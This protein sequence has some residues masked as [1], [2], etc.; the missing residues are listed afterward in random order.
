MTSKCATTARRRHLDAAQRFFLATAVSTVL[1]LAATSANARDTSPAAQAFEQQDYDTAMRLSVP[2][3]QNGDAAAQYRLAMMYR[4]G[5]GVGRDFLLA[6]EWFEKSAAQGY[7]LSAAELGKIHKDGRGVD[8]NPVEAVK[9]FRQ[10]AE[11]GFGVAQLNLARML[12]DGEGVPSDPVE[13]HAWF[14]LAVDN[15]YMDAIGHRNRLTSTMTP[16]QIEQAKARAVEL[17]KTVKP[18]TAE[19]Q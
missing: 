7:G 1:G 11:D 15:Q 3:A 10:G 19:E 4:F 13:A 2:L 17:R 12:R 6:R 18:R 16:E 9:W 5:W 14:S 8:K